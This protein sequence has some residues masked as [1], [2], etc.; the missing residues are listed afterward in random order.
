M[1]T[2][3]HT[4]ISL[5]ETPQPEGHYQKRTNHCSGLLADRAEASSQL[6]Q[7]E[8]G[9]GGHSEYCDRDDRREDHA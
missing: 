8:N 7:N 5:Y 6:R 9:K 4:V 2:L 3:F 1:Q